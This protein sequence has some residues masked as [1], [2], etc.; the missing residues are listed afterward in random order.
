MILITGGLGFIGSHVTRAL[1]G[2]DEACVLVQRRVASIPGLLADEVGARVLAE[3]ADVADLATL[4]DI[5]NR[6]KITGIVHLAGG[7]GPGTSDPIGGVRAGTDGLLNMLQVAMDWQV[8]RVGIASTIGVYDGPGESPLREDLPLPLTSAHPIP[9]AKKMHELIGGYVANATGLE[10]YNVRIAAA[11][12]PLGRP[13][14]RFFA[15]PQMVHAAVRGEVP[16]PAYADDGIDMVYVRDCG[17]AIAQLQLAGRLSHR[18]YNVATGRA[19]TNAGLAAALKKVIPGARIE[20]RDGRD[21]NGLGRDV[22]LDIARIHA[23]TGYQ[24]AYDTETAAADYVAW[25]RSG[26]ER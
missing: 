5:G 1:L 12:G 19:T 3:Q 18:T 8:P 9:A 15:A 11:W 26:N 16:P 21:P 24:P 13:V 2:L 10:I 14:S 4:Q 6:H 7:F 22:F 17:R 25:L 23:D 20:L